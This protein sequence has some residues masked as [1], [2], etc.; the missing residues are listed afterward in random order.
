MQLLLHGMNKN[1]SITL[2]IYEQKSSLA[3]LISTATNEKEDWKLFENP[4]GTVQALSFG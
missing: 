3:Q 1:F 2:R 4:L